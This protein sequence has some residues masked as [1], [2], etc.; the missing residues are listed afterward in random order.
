MPLRT[1]VSC[2]VRSS[3]GERGASDLE[4]DLTQ[5]LA[6]VEEEVHTTTH[7]IK[8]ASN[9]RQQI[10]QRMANVKRKL[11]QPG[12]SASVV[13]DLLD[14]LEDAKGDK[15]SIDDDKKWYSKSLT[16]LY[17]KLARL[18]AAKQDLGSPQ[19]KTVDVLDLVRCA[20]APP[21]ISQYATTFSETL[22]ALRGNAA[23][24]KQL[25]LSTSSA[26]VPRDDK[27]DVLLAE[28]PAGAG[29]TR[30]GFE[31]LRR[32]EQPE[33][34]LHDIL[35]TSDGS[36]TV[37]VGLFLDFNNG[38]GLNNDI[39]CSSMDK[40]MAVRL[41]ARYLGVSMS[42]VQKL[43]GGTLDGLSTAKVLSAIADGVVDRASSSTSMPPLVGVLFVVHL[44]EYQVY[45]QALTK[46]KKASAMTGLMPPT[47]GKTQVMQCFKEMLSAVNNWAR[48]PKNSKRAR[49]SFLPVVS[50]T[51]VTGLEFKVT[52]KLTEVP[53]RPGRL[54]QDDA[55]ALVA[56][57]I[58]AVNSG[59]HRKD[60]VQLLGGQEA[61]I[62]MSDVDFRPRFLVVMGTSIKSLVRRTRAVSPI[63]LDWAVVTN[64]VLRRVPASRKTKASIALALFVLSQTRVPRD[65]LSGGKNL[66]A[67]YRSLASAV[68]SG[69][70]E[71]DLVDDNCFV[72]RVPLM[73]LRRWPVAHVFPP[74]LFGLLSSPWKDVEFAFA[75][76][77][78]ARLSP[79]LRS[80]SLTIRDIFTGVRGA[81]LLPDFKLDLETDSERNVYVQSSQLFTNM[82]SRLT[83]R[84]QL[85][86][87]RAHGGGNIEPVDV[88]ES[89]I[90]TCPGTMAIDIYCA[91]PL[92]G[93]DSG[94]VYVIAQTKKT[95]NA[96]TV[97]LAA[98]E[99]WY[100][101]VSTLTKEWQCGGNEVV[102]VFFTNKRLAD[103]T[104]AAMDVQFFLD[105][106]G[107]CV[108]S[109][110]ELDQVIPSLMRTR[111]V[112]AE[113]EKR[114]S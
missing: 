86:A 32:L 41:A 78:R 87:S 92:A 25:E 76:C 52:D 38:L 46:R 63:V 34:A 37:A 60:V 88:R 9:E 54:N 35:T 64:E 12:L 22:F 6:E 95:D 114:A 102:Y 83:K 108:T 112:T 74:S 105:R 14:D 55:G 58:C 82:A 13:A 39:D 104:K 40:N 3:A 11:K 49:M 106:P 62:F 97:S 69:E 26:L 28:G 68:Q 47:F 48:D 98:I 5:N 90:L 85:Q 66:S 15:A 45:L 75:Y 43:N 81:S 94:H 99:K 17:E 8:S 70:V 79:G 20:S 23:A 65:V 77:L 113:Q 2:R 67:A 42:E 53:F 36:R 27:S 103:E 16:L 24:M 57:V 50:G 72:A 56:D 30:L 109:Y 18:K 31:V 21:V 71:V 100:G 89:I 91:I 4:R 59:I 73:Q 93:K 61:R 84:Y 111:F 101:I 7:A 110:D 19:T 10:V 80:S 51:P 96:V 33:G 107:L 1:P 29:K 44:D